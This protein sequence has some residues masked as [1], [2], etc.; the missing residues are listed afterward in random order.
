MAARDEDITGASDQDTTNWAT[1][2][3]NPMLL[4]WQWMSSLNAIHF[5]GSIK[6]NL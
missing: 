4:Q 3:G 6:A 2:K 5:Y 1:M